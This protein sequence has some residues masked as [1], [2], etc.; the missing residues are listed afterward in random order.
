MGRKESKQTNKGGKIVVGGGGAHKWCLHLKF[1][2]DLKK[3]WGES[4]DPST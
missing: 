1:R 4:S 3:F 2:E